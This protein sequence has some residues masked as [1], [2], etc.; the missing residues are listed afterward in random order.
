MSVSI[1]LARFGA[2]NSPFFRVIAQTTRSKVNGNNHAIL[3][4][5]DPR[6]KK[7][8]LDKALL[9]AWVKKG[10]ILTEGVKKLLK[11]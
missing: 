7:L 11:Q 5:Y 9:E 2:K 8:E 4:S 6:H 3:G 10:A 1:K